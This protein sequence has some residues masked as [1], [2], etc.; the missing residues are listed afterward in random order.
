LSK[1]RAKVSGPLYD[2]GF[3]LIHGNMVGFED[4]A[5]RLIDI[6]SGALVTDQRG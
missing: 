3:R 5:S 4:S 6:D 2:A 1:F